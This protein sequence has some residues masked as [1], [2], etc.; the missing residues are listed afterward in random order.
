MVDWP[1]RGNR[2]KKSSYNEPRHKISTT[3]LVEQSRS[4]FESHDITLAY[5]PDMDEINAYPVHDRSTTAKQNLRNRAIPTTL[6]KRG[7]P[8][9]ES[10]NIKREGS[11]SKRVTLDTDVER[12]P[13]TNNRRRFSPPVKQF[14]RAEIEAENA[15]RD[16]TPNKK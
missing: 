3:T 9:A 15:K 5:N 10:Q 14:T 6:L 13:R 2:G 7:N 4:Q 12:T 11:Q 16:Q 1:E 8:F